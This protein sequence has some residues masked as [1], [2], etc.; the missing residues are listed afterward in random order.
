MALGITNASCKTLAHSLTTCWADF[1]LNIFISPCDHFG[2]N[3]PELSEQ[4]FNLPSP[5]TLSYNSDEL[6]MDGGLT[7]DTDI[8]I[9]DPELHS[10]G[11]KW[12]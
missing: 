3:V 12:H 5:L 10:K 6:T 8:S 11:L 7:K 2:Y 9:P 4:I 1:S